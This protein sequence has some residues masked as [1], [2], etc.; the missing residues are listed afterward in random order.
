MKI[1]D[2]LHKIRDFFDWYLGIPT[3]KRIQ[4]NYIA[5]IAIIIT[6][7]YYN[8]KQHRENYLALTA[9]IDATN[10]SRSKEQEKYAQNLQ[11]YTEKYS[12]LYKEILN[13]K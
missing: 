5:F 7:A 3:V 11:Y 6:G 1:F 13:T 12:E 4:I 2:F 9:R 8:D 10:D